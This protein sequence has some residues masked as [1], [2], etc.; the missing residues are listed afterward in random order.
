M[1]TMDAPDKPRRL[2]RRGFSILAFC[3]TCGHQAP[4]DRTQVPVGVT[5]QPLWMRLSCSACGSREASHR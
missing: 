5:V 4:V 2:H 1:S 3:D